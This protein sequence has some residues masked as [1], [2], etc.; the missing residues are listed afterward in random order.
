MF[1]RYTEKARRVIFF[2]RYEASQFGSPY[3]ETEHLLL[4]LLREDKALTHRFLSGQAEVESIRQQIEAATTVREKVSTSVDL[5][6]SNEGK[7]VLAYAAEEA[8]RLAHQHIG[9]EHLLLGL[10]REENSFAARLLSERGLSLSAV[11]E[12]LQPAMDESASTAPESTAPQASEFVL[13]SDFS[14]YITRLARENRLLP[15]IGRENELEQAMHILGR[16]SKNNVVL[17]GEPGV[18]KRTIVDGLAQRATQSM[19]PAFLEDKLFT[20][21]DLSMVVTAAQHS[22]RAKEFLSAVATELI[23]GGPQ[24]IYFFDELHHLLAA[25]PEGGAHEVTLLLKAALLNGKV[26]CVASATPEEYG[27]AL[28]KAR[29][30]EQCFLPVEVRPATEAATIAILQVNRKRFE[31]FHSVQYTDE[32]MTAAVVYA[33]RYVKNRYLPDTA[34]DLIDDAGAYVKLKQEKV[35][36]PEEVIE[37][38]KRLKFI[39]NRHEMAVTNKEFEKARFYADEERNQRD[40]LRDLQQKHNIQSNFIGTVMPEDIE[41]VLARWTGISAA[42][43]R[44]SAALE[45]KAADEKPLGVKRARGK[46]KKK[47]S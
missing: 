8:E 32:A 23:R 39:G 6:L 26:H 36:L 40:A 33:R 13:L 5:P 30:L 20:A 15:L 45:V 35:A 1:E 21:I 9:T 17:V 16:S 11:R 34:I 2:A 28:K 44:T 31:I 25:G 19:P 38:R 47:S 37:A 24:A 41:E 18:G 14:T 29:W 7:R 12:Q 10:L 4:G 3:I 22:A 42:T 46:A 27:T 43:I